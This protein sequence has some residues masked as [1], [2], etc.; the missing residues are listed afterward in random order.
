MRGRSNTHFNPQIY[1]QEVFPRQ[2]GCYLGKNP[3]K[4][5]HLGCFLLGPR[6]Q[7]L[8]TSE[9]E[10]DDDPAA[11]EAKAEKEEAAISGIFFLKG[12]DMDRLMKCWKIPWVILG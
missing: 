12:R 7:G 9:A 6:L 8:T 1:T 5:S 11:E 4:T 2:T 10:A 3:I